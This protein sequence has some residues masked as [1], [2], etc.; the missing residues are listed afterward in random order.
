MAYGKPF[1]VNRPPKTGTMLN[2]IT[3]N[4]NG[5]RSAISKGFWEWLGQ[6]NPDIGGSANLDIGTQQE[7]SYLRRSIVQGV[8]IT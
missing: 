2:I 7:Q 6:E 5:I 1:T 8:D 3:Y 4:V